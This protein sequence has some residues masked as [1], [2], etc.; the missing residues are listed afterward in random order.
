MSE[1]KAKRSKKIILIFVAIVLAAVAIAGLAVT[2]IFNYNAFSP[3][4]PIVVDDGEN[5]M[6]TMSLND[7]YDGYRFIFKN[8]KEEFI[9]DSEK[10]YLTSKEIVEKSKEGKDKGVEIGKNYKVSVCY[11]STNVGNNSELSDEIDWLCAIYLSSPE[12]SVKEG[13]LTWQTVEYADSYRIY[14]GDKYKDVDKTQTSLNL[15]ELGGG[16]KTISVVAKSNAE[17]Y[18]T[19][20][21]SK[22]ISLKIIYNLEPFTSIDFDKDSCIITAACTREYDKIIV[23]IGSIEYEV[24]EFKVTKDGDIFT[25]QI[26]I[27]AKYN[28]E[29]QIGIKPADIDE[30]NIYSGNILF[31]E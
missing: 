14:Y 25:Y 11:L 15:Q 28:G 4:K 22:Q 16:E 8:G 3:E 21:A 13:S 31:V 7:N 30:Y 20:A 19:S 6:I 27:K 23:A 9:I 12:V 5:I 2:F 10:N 29:S 17:G 1:E 18:K 26:N 24:K